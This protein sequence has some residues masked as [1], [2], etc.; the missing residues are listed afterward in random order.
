MRNAEYWI[1]YYNLK[2]HPKGCGY[3][4]ETFR[5]KEQI[6]INNVEGNERISLSTGIISLFEGNQLT[7]LHQ[8]KSH[9]N[10]HYYTG[11][12]NLLVHV[13]NSATEK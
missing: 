4:I 2:P 3:F 6:K 1:Q 7:Y 12:T 10:I 13:H 9:Q 5:A 8:T 11:T